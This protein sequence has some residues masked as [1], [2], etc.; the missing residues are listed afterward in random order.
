MILKMF[1]TLLL[2]MLTHGFEDGD[3][4]ID[5][6][7]VHAAYA[8][9]NVAASDDTNAHVHEDG[10]NVVPD[11]NVS[12]DVNEVMLIFLSIAYFKEDDNF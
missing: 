6:N 8:D 9:S 2:I 3:V 10:D 7:N 1:M 12:G 11:V 4:V 5:Y